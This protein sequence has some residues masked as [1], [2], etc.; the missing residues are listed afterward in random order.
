VKFELTKTI[1]ACRLCAGELPLGQKPIIWSNP[2]AKTLII[3]QAPGMRI[4]ELGVP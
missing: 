2:G 1:R 3:G 4:Y